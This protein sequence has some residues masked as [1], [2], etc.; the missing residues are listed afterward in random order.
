MLLNGGG[1]FEFSYYVNN[2]TTDKITT[3]FYLSKR[4]NVMVPNSID[5][6]GLDTLGIFTFCENGIVENVTIPDNI[7]SIE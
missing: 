4:K 5:D 3:I 2:E 7:T 1:D 6:H